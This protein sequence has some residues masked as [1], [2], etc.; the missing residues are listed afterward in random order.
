MGT[1]SSLIFDHCTR[2]VLSVDQ[3]IELLMMDKSI[4][5]VLFEDDPDIDLMNK[6]SRNLLD[7]SWNINTDKYAYITPDQ[8]HEVK[9]DTWLIPEK[10]KLLD[11]ESHIMGLC[12]TEEERVRV[13]L[14]LDMFRERDMFDLLRVLVYMIDHFRE[15]NYI[16]GVGR[17]SSVSSY[18]LFLIGV[19]KVDSLKYQ[20]DIGEFLK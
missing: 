8:F 4:S 7:E 20:L 19:H 17:G 1:S 12:N 9:R 11:I 10:Y 14:E 15:H 13:I 2:P 18:C 6:H 5:G 3:G 16:W